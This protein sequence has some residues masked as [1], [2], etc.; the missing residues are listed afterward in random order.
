MYTVTGPS[1][2]MEPETKVELPRRRSEIDGKDDRVKVG[3]VRIRYLGERGSTSWDR[4]ALEGRG[5]DFD[6]DAV[7]D[8][9]MMTCSEKK[10]QI[11]F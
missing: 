3:R 1:E 5:I 2:M 6:E 7:S 10:T 11:R 4:D 8:V 9:M